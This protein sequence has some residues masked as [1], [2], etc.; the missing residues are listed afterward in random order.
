MPKRAIPSKV[1]ADNRFKT[2]LEY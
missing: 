2:I 1:T